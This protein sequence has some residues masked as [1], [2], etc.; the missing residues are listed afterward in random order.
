MKQSHTSGPW[1]SYRAFANNAPDYWLVSN[2]AFKGET[3]ATCDNEANARLIAQSPA[4]LH[5]VQSLLPIARDHL[6]AI[7]DSQCNLVADSD[8]VTQLKA[9]IT[10]C[11]K[12]IER[13]TLC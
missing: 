9:I 1:Q 11:E 7:K 12:T 10:Q 6:A 13:V 2:R 3:I 4:L 5:L 8:Q